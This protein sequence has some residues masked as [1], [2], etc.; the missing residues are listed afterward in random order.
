MSKEKKAAN[1]RVPGSIDEAEE[2]EKAGIEGVADMK[3][4]EEV[5]AVGPLRSVRSEQKEST[6]IEG[7]RTKKKRKSSKKSIYE[8]YADGRR[9]PC[10]LSRERVKHRSVLIYEEGQGWDTQSMKEFVTLIERLEMR[11]VYLVE[12]AKFIVIKGR[13]DD[14]DRCRVREE[15]MFALAKEY[16]NGCH[17]VREVYDWR[18]FHLLMYRDARKGY[19]FGDIRGR[20]EHFVISSLDVNFD[21]LKRNGLWPL[22]KREN[23]HQCDHKKMQRN[24]SSKNHK[25]CNKVMHRARKMI[26]SIL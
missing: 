13:P 10:K 19:V 4:E 17:H 9:A 25:G 7:Q 22:Q 16:S 11:R 26:K 24:E 15:L 20:D 23:G 14:E 1:W 5:D 21:Y 18:I 6:E 3:V 2:D 12:D 8:T